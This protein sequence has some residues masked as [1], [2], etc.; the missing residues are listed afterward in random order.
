MC[1]CVGAL[2][3]GHVVSTVA[4]VFQLARRERVLE[5]DVFRF[6]TATS[7]PLLFGVAGG[8]GGQRLQRRPSGVDHF[9]VVLR[10]FRQVRSAFG[11]QTW[12][13]DVS[14]SE[15]SDFCL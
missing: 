7:V 10:V 5:R 9:V 3:W 6:G 1:G 8:V 11:T 4:V 2:H 13:A 12:A 14:L 15:V